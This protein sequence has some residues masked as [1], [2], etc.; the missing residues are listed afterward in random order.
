M[1]LFKINRGN[2]TTLPTSLTDGWAY[3]CTDTGEF[4]IDYA[5]SN[6]SLHRKQI[7]ADE[8]KKISG[9]DVATTLNNS[10]IEIPTSSSVCVAI[11][12]AISSFVEASEEDILALFQ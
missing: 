1:A 9:Y 12:S 7:N 5:D 10:T 8:A 11:E 2:S 3:F 6:G 4:F